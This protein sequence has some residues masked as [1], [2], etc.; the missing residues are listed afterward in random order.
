MNTTHTKPSAQSDFFPEADE[1]IK[2]APIKVPDLHIKRIDQQTLHLMQNMGAG[3][4][5]IIEICPFHVRLMAE[6]VGLIPVPDKPEG[7]A[8]KRVGILEDRLMMLT[9]RIDDLKEYLQR[10]SDHDHA[11]LSHEVMLT[12]ALHDVAKV[13]I[14]DIVDSA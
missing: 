14:A 4:Q 6:V 10:F 7:A 2:A 1:I 12:N 11:D 5:T 8:L 3:E 13:C 9:A